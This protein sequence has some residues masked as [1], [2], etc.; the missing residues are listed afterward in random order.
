METESQPW[1]A[2]SADP[3]QFCRDT[4]KDLR[5]RAD[6]SRQE[7][8]ALVLVILVSTMAIPAFIGLGNGLFWA[9]IFPGALAV[10]AAASMAW[11]QVR[12]PQQQW[13]LFRTGQCKL[14]WHLEQYR[15][16][17]GQ[18]AGKDGA[19]VLVDTVMEVAWEMHRRTFPVPGMPPTLSLLGRLPRD[20][21]T[22]A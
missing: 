10:M 2:S 16:R 3:D 17:R 21:E 18:Y 1:P 8:Q 11:L 5:G 4:I 7:G 19:A 22:T 12:Q 20:A 9:Q 13:V 6:L 15:R 14:E